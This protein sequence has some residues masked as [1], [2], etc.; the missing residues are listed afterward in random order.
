MSGYTFP[1]AGKAEPLGGGGLDADPARAKAQA[2]A[3]VL[4]HGLHMRAQL[5]RLAHHR[6]VDIGDVISGLA[7]QVAGVGEQLQAAG[8]FVARI[9]VR[10]VRAQVSQGRGPQQ[11]VDDSMG[12]HVG[13]R[14]SQQPC[15]MLQLHAA[16]DQLPVGDQAMD[17]VAESS[18]K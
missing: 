8:V 11:G 13:V 5:G 15:L 10:K 6:D 4:L 12:Q 14:V 18:A 17:I 2:T 7:H 16:Q 3:Q 9:M 1:A